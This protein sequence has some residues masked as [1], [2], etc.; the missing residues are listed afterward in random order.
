MTGKAGSYSDHT[1]E[2]TG[3]AR[4]VLSFGEY[5]GAKMPVVRTGSVKSSILTRNH[6]LHKITWGTAG[7]QLEQCDQARPGHR[8]AHDHRAARQNA[9][10]QFA[11]Q[12]AGPSKAFTIGQ[13][14]DAMTAFDTDLLLNFPRTTKFACAARPHLRGRSAGI[15]P[16]APRQHD[17][18]IAEWPKV[19]QLVTWTEAISRSFIP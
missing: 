8:G 12:L 14:L 3:S 1:S 13:T 10:W 4:S 15:Q 7:V 17:S 5:L 2:G 18:I 6:S 11:R 19:V 16:D 9:R